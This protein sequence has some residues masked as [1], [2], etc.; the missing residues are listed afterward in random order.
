MPKG[1]TLA[2]KAGT[3][4]VKGPKGELSKNLP[5]GITIKTEGDKFHPLAGCSTHHQ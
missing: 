1:V 2:Q 3:F 4:S 5:E